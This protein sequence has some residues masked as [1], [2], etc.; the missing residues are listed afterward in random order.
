MRIRLFLTILL[1][2]ITLTQITAQTDLCPNV[3]TQLSE[4]EL[5]QVTQ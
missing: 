1:M 2:L 4:G 3:I 5:A